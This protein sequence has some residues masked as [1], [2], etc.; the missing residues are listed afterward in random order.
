MNIGKKRN[1]SL[2]FN[3]LFSPPEQSS[4]KSTLGIRRHLMPATFRIIDVA[5]GHTLGAVV[6]RF[7][8]IPLA[9]VRLA[10][11]ALGGFAM[12]GVRFRVVSSVFGDASSSIIQS[13]IIFATG[14]F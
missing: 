4:H 10:A 8:A 7:F 11:T 12:T 13:A 5:F 6:A 9:T 14:F 1:V 2:C 3:Y